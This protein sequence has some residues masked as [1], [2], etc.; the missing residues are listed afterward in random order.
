VR[1]VTEL[2][3]QST[4]AFVFCCPFLH[5]PKCAAVTWCKAKVD[6]QLMK[7]QCYA[8]LYGFSGRCSWDRCSSGTWLCLSEWSVNGILN[9][10]IWSLTTAIDSSETS[11]PNHPVMSK[12]ISEKRRQEDPRTSG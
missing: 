2:W 6:I 10:T 4:A 1:Q 3:I 8:S 9:S 12:N 11:N 5:K 7:T